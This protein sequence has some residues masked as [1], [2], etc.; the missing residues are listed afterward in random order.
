MICYS[1]NWKLRYW[2]S[3]IPMKPST[4][5]FHP[6]L[7][8]FPIQLQ[9]FCFSEVSFFLTHTLDSFPLP[10][11]LPLYEFLWLGRDF[12]L[13]LEWVSEDMVSSSMNYYI[14]NY[15]IIFDCPDS[16]DA[17]MLKD[18]KQNELNFCRVPALMSWK[19]GRFKDLTLWTHIDWLKRYTQ[20]QL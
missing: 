6:T 12:C 2:V 18:F 20:K 7:F 14:M 9:L 4:I 11:C 1:N 8:L 15:Y 3:S 17:Q 16:S 5:W 10:R 19:W 13:L